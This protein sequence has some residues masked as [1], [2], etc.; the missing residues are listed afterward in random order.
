MSWGVSS[1][2]YPVWNSLGFLD[3]GDYFLPHFR[4]VFNY[5][6]LKYFLM[7]FLFV[8]FFWDSYNSNVGAFHIVLEVS[9]IVLISFN[10]FF[11]PSLI[12]LFLPFYFTNP[13]F[14]LQLFYYLLPP[15]CSWSHLL[16]Y[17]LYID[18]FL[19]K[20]FSKK[21]LVWFMSK[22]VSSLFSSRNFVVS[23]VT[24]KS[25]S[26]FELIFVY[27]VRMF[28]SFTDLHAANFSSPTCWRTVFSPSYILSSFIKN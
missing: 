4:E 5:Y 1:W 15:G 10:S 21:T 13:I 3:L 16:P 25:L 11:F 22:N 2:V 9:E 19:K 20:T 28:S 12:H 8:F 26:H 18:S 17:S 23:C 27:D 24:F 7:V 14:C 6:L